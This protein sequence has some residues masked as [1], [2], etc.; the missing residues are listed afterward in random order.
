[1]LVAPTLAATVARRREAGPSDP[2]GTTTHAN[3]TCRSLPPH[4]G[5]AGRPR[6]AASPAA[7]PWV[8]SEPCAPRAEA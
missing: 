6:L 7:G 3:L 8:D 2:P 4:T 5:A 1:V